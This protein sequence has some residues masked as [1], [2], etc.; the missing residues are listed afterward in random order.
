M[1]YLWIQIKELIILKHSG[2]IC[3]GMKTRDRV[4]TWG[5]FLTLY[6]Q[7]TQCILAPISHHSSCTFLSFYLPLSLCLSLCSSILTS[8]LLFF[9]FFLFFSIYF[10]LFTYI[11]FL[12]SF[13]H[14]VYNI[15][16]KSSHC[17]CWIMFSSPTL[18][19]RTN[20]KSLHSLN[21]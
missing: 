21:N 13:R 19:I 4:N 18:K 7:T 1:N 12:H 2:K 5:H 6:I 20:K 3:N 8:S 17:S 11:L 15:K 14:P 16:F 9:P 10:A